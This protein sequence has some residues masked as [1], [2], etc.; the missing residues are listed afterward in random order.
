VELLFYV[1]PLIFPDILITTVILSA[2]GILLAALLLYGTH[3]VSSEN[4]GM[5]YVYIKLIQYVL[6]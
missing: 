6:I 4:N 1:L 3:N 2:I 5:D